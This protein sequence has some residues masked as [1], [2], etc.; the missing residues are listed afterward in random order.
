MASA[1]GAPSVPEQPVPFV[2]ALEDRGR[3]HRGDVRGREVDRE[4]DAIE[5]SAKLTDRFRVV[6]GQL[7]SVAGGLRSLDEESLR[8]VAW[9]WPHREPRFAVDT[10]H[11]LAG[12]KDSDRGAATHD[13]VHDTSNRVYKVLAVVE[14]HQRMTSRQRPHQRLLAISL[15]VL[16]QTHRGRDLAR[17]EGLVVDRRKIDKPCTIREMRKRSRRSLEREACLSHP[18]GAGQRDQT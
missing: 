1:C 12:S 11:L 5:A 9:Q 16:R 17:H 7:E 6:R 3:T 18:T 10:E 15:T 14:H 13:Q 8:V 2:D 4:R